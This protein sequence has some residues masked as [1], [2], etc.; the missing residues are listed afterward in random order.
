MV[1]AA[2]EAQPASVKSVESPEMSV[3]RQEARHRQRR[4]VYNDDGCYSDAY[5]TPEKFLS[6]RLRGA[7]GTQVDTV[8]FCTGVTTLYFAHFPQVG[9]LYGEFVTESSSEPAKIGRDSLLALKKAGQDPLD[10]ATDFCH[11][12]K[13]EIFWSQR[14]NDI[15]DSLPACDEM[16]SRWKREHPE[17]LMGTREEAKN[18]RDSEPRYWWTALDFGRPEVLE[19][20]YRITEDICRRYD[21][22]GIECDYWRSPMLF[23][24][25]LDRQPATAEQ[26]DLLTEW[27]RRIREMTRREGERRGRPILV[28]ARVPASEA[29]CLRVGIDIERWLK[30]DLIDVMPIGGGCLPF[31]MPT[32]EMVKLGHDHGVPVYP[33]ISHSR[34]IYNPSENWGPRALW[35]EGWRGA[36]ENFWRAGADGI[37]T[38][39]FMPTPNEPLVKELFQQIGSPQTLANLDK[40]FEIDYVPEFEG[41]STEAVPVSRAL[42]VPLYPIAWLHQASLPIG[43]DIPQAAKDGKLE[44]ATMR[45]QLRGWQAGDAVEVR[46][47]GAV[48]S[49]VKEE[50]QAEWVWLTFHPEAT[51]YRLGDNDVEFLV[52]KRAPG[53]KEPLV[54]SAVEV[55]VDYK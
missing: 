3:R 42:P 54:V 44:A 35:R 6:Q 16:L 11:K 53:A 10:L 36:A 52:V 24:P 25:N 47:N 39:N 19:Y 17:Y 50:P 32:A 5:D 13:L 14:M 30:E 49:P 55:H 43:D 40:L 1:C 7:A 38:F 21:V 9:E 29:N 45:V 34:M 46:L 28:A 51:Q 27:H 31:T 22:D 15:H 23:R 18:Y 4:I 26:R 2:E 8:F 48:L 12:N 33:C 41:D 37:Y 20:L